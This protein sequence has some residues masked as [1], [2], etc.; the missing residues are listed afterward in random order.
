MK[1]CCKNPAKI[2]P[3]DVSLDETAVIMFKCNSV[4]K[5]SLRTGG[6]GKAVQGQKKIGFKPQK[7]FLR[8]LK[9]F[10]AY[11]TFAPKIFTLSKWVDETD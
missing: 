9:V 6:Q 1:H 7:F 8:V 11:L 3:N 10:C 2:F 4:I 5:A